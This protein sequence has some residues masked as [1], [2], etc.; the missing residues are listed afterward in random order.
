[1][2]A[3]ARPGVYVPR[4]THDAAALVRQHLPGFLARLEEAGHARGDELRFQRSLQLKRRLATDVAKSRRPLQIAGKPSAC[5]TP[6]SATWYAASA[7]R[8][9]RYTSTRPSCA[10]TA[11]KKGVLSTKKDCSA[12]S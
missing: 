4:Q 5:S 8:C 6:A 2:P 7:R 3:C 12:S 11:T 9:S 10:R 1:M